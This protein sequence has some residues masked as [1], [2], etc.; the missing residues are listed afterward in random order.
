MTPYFTV[1]V[2]IEYSAKDSVYLVFAIDRNTLRFSLHLAESV[3]REI[4]KTK[5]SVIVLFLSSS[6]SESQT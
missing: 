1:W 3:A 6:C 2:N 4:Q 5:R